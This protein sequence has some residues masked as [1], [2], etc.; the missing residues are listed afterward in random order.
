M[1]TTTVRH[2]CWRRGEKP[3]RYAPLPLHNPAPP[4]EQESFSAQEMAAIEQVL[5]QMDD[6]ESATGCDY[7]DGPMSSHGCH[8]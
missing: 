5:Q 8:W 1:P 3:A 6:G 4:I 7:P 2:A